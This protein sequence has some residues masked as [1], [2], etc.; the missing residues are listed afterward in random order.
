MWQAAS[1]EV[2]MKSLQA[3]AAA[4]TAGWGAR[5]STP[6]SRPYS[7]SHLPLFCH[8]PQAPTQAWLLYHPLPCHLGGLPVQPRLDLTPRGPSLASITFSNWLTSA[9]KNGLCFCQ[10]YELNVCGSFSINSEFSKYTIVLSLIMD[11]LLIFS[12]SSLLL[13]SSIP[14]SLFYI[15]ED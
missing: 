12:G 5:H 7:A 10:F 1:S 15:W 11:F 6:P 9:Q 14:I 4:G 3:V 2:K 8:L 13:R